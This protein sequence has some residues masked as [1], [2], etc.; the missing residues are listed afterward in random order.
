MK[1]NRALSRSA[2]AAAL[3]V[4]GASAQAAL[5]VTSPACTASVL[6]PNYTA[7]GGSF[8][9]NNQNQEA[10]V[11]SFI[12]TTWGQT[13]T[14]QGSSDTPVSFGPFTS[15]PDTTTGT[16]TFDFAIDQAFVLALKAGNQF[17][18]FYFDGSGPAI[19]SI[20]YST[21]GV[22]VNNQGVPNGLSHATL[23]SGTLVPSIPEPET[24]ALMLAGLGA[25]GFMARRRRA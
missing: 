14:D 6:T 24:Y 13:F 3:V 16:L 12:S 20:D 5:T 23:Y 15:N 9:G 10:D 11:L 19:T 7:C 17:S 21:L 8:A 2:I 25:V 18:L 22:N 1:F 4:A